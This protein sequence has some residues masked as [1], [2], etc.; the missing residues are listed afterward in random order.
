MENRTAKLVTFGR[1]GD[2]VYYSRNC[3]STGYGNPDNPHAADP[4]NHD[5]PDGTP[6]I[7][8]RPA[9]ETTEGF[10]WVVRGPMVDVDLEDGAVDR[11]PEPSPVMQAAMSGNSYGA[12]L[13]IHAAHKIIR[14]DEP[15]PLDSVSIREYIEGWRK[16]GARIGAYQNGMIVWES[17]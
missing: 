2:T 10:R 11:L 5:I 6:V 9:V 1:G 15:G 16:V 12:L 13:T 17:A 8:K 7:D 14:K 4:A 3:H